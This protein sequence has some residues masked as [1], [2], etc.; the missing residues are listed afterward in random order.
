MTEDLV[1]CHRNPGCWFAAS[2]TMARDMARDKSWEAVLDPVKAT[3]FFAAPQ[4]RPLF[5]PEQ[6]QW[7]LANA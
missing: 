2:V 1:R 4:E 6:P 3:N 5:V 7:H